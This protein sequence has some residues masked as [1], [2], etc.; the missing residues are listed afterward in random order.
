MLRG[1]A[2]RSSVTIDGS[3]RKSTRLNSSYDQISY[4][5]FCLKKKKI[6]RG[7]TLETTRQNSSI[8]SFSPIFRGIP[9]STHLLCS[10]TYPNCANQNAFGAVV[11]AVVTGN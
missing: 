7:P 1:S 5:V 6:F 9:V 2:L 4:A 8:S 10:V 3:D 11:L